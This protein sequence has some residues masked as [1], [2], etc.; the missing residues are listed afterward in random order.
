MAQPLRIEYPGAVY[1]PF[2]DLGVI[3]I[4]YPRFQNKISCNTTS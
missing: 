4:V 1:D 2:K 3:E